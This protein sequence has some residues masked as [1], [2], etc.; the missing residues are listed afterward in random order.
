MCRVFLLWW[1]FSWQICHS[2][3]I[4]RLQSCFLHINFFSR[5]AWIF[6]IHFGL[7]GHVNKLIFLS[8]SFLPHFSELTFRHQRTHIL[9]FLAWIMKNTV[10]II[11]SLKHYVPKPSYDLLLL[12]VEH[13]RHFLS[14]SHMGEKLLLNGLLCVRGRDVWT[15]LSH[16]KA[17]LH[18]LEAFYSTLSCNDLEE[19]FDTVLFPP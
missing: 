16:I 13:Q 18:P 1:R 8:C 4:T 9:I 3:I 2:W 14:D 19:F 11:Q 5:G 6:M 17:G 15:S 12:W 7:H 10:F